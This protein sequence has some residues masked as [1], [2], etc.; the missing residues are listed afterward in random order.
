MVVVRQL[1]LFESNGSDRTTFP[2]AADV[3]VD[4]SAMAVSA[5]YCAFA[6]FVIFGVG[7]TVCVR[8]SVGDGVIVNVG[9]KVG[10]RVRVGVGDGKY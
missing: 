8:V 1:C 10:V 3:A 5:K 2:L 4:W 6:V 7:V 9:V